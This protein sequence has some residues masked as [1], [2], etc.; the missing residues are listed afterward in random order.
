MLA[1][2]ERNAYSRFVNAI[3][4]GFMPL[5]PT[6]INDDKIVKWAYNV[7]LTRFT[8]VWQPSR[9]KLI[10]P[11]ADLVSTRFILYSLINRWPFTYEHSFFLSI[12]P[13]QS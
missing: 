6:T 13:V 9:Q 7:A 2:N 1:T 3:R 12:N 10:A 8:E 5:Q 4:K 11:M